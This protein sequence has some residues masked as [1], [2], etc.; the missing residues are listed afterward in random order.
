MVVS[1]DSSA[2]ESVEETPCYNMSTCRPIMLA[3]VPHLRHADM[4]P[5]RGPN[6]SQTRS[7]ARSPNGAE[8]S[9]KPSLR[10]VR[11]QGGVT[12]DANSRRSLLVE[13]GGFV[14][15]GP[16]SINVR[17]GGCGMRSFSMAAPSPASI[18]KHGAVLFCGVATARSEDQIV[19]VGRSLESS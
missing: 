9:C 11:L 8:M 18:R 5:T 16:W 6:G 7:Y 4:P 2:P 19:V 12:Q 10:R 14:I 1:F 15:R 17:H 13:L 3:S